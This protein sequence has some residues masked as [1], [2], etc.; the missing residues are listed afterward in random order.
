[1]K[2][3]VSILVLMLTLLSIEYIRAQNDTFGV[4]AGANY[5][6]STSIVRNAN[7]LYFFGIP[8]WCFLYH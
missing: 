5:T 6:R 4:R 3:I 1:M 2:K 8:Y 7:F